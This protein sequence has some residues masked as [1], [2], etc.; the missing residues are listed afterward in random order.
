MPTYKLLFTERTKMNDQER[1][2]EI[3]NHLLEKNLSLARFYKKLME[4]IP[5][6]RIKN[7]FSKLSSR[8][9]QF[10]F[11]LSREIENYGEHISS[12][13]ASQ[14]VIS[15]RNRFQHQGGNSFRYLKHCIR[16]NKDTLKE[17]RK[18]L[19]LINNGDSREILLRHKSIMEI[20][21]MELKNLKPRLQTEVEKDVFVIQSK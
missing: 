1:Y 14:G 17:Y 20:I 21:I 11:E 7:Y 13:D 16:I 15:F 18:A 3:L 9:A 10:T 5:E 6:I 19:S 4:A 2:A 12:F 8:M